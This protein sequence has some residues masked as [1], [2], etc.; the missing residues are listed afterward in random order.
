MIRLC[1][2]VNYFYQAPPGVKIC[3]GTESY[4]IAKYITQIKGMKDMTNVCL[5]NCEGTYLQMYVWF[6]QTP[7]IILK[8]D[9]L[10][11][12]MVIKKNFFEMKFIATYDIT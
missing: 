1:G 3:N 9:N 12:E 11:Y 4:C 7:H 5:P 8:H 2:C 6:F 10:I